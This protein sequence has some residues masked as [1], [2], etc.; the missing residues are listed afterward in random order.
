[1]QQGIK[2]MKCHLDLDFVALADMMRDVGF[3]DVVL[4]P[5]KIPIGKW[6]ADPRLNEAG[7]LQQ[8][9]ML[10]GI[11]SLSLAVFTRCLNWDPLEVQI[12]LAKAR[13]D[14]CIKKACTYW[15]WLVH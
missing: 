15:P 1:M 9:A 6:P 13:K 7:A 3:V 5:F 10:E 8:V 12:L 2:M 11:E 14:F 4:R